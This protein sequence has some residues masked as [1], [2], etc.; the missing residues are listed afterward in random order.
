M[1]SARK[2]PMRTAGE[3]S[4]LAFAVW[5]LTSAME[6]VADSNHQLQVNTAISLEKLSGTVSGIGQDLA[7]FSQK[8][9]DLAQ[10]RDDHEQRLRYLE[11]KR[12]TPNDDD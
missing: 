7:S 5:Q 9:L 8:V 4:A 11:K 1:E 12:R 10:A 6:K 2:G 3:L